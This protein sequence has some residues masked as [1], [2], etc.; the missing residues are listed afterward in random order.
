MIR[1]TLCFAAA[2]IIR[3][4][5]TNSISVF[6]VLEDFAPAGLPFFIPYLACVALWERE[7]G[8]AQRVQGTFTVQLG[9]DTLSTVQMHVDFGEVRRSRSMININGL[10]VPR[11]GALRFRFVLETGPTAEYSLNVEA[12]PAVAAQAVS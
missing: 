8:D 3:D 6:N 4:A 11:S 9:N 10:A 2:A 5:A 1:S 7:A 12:P